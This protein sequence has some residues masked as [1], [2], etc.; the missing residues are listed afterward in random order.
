MKAIHRSVAIPRPV[1]QCVGQAWL[2]SSLA[3]VLALL[4]S[5]TPIQPAAAP[6]PITLRF[7][8]AAGQ[9]SPRIDLY[10][11]EFGT[12][13]HA[14]SQGNITVEPVWDAGADAPDG[15]FE[16]KAIQRVQQGE[17]ELGMAP[18]RAFDI[19]H[20]TSFQPLQAP[21]LIANDA[22]AEA[23]ATSDITTKMLDHLSTADMV[24]L[25]LWPED[26]RH[27]FS[28][29]SGKPLLS[30]QDFAGVN[31]RTPRS[32]LGFQLISALGGTAMYGDG[33]YQG[34]ESGLQQGGTL[35]GKPIATGNVTF[36]PKYEVLFANA[37]AFTRLTDE[38]RMILRQAATA[39]QKKAL[40]N[41]PK[42]VDAA[43]AYCADGG[44][45]V[46]ASDEQVKAFEQAT[47]P[48]FEQ[49]EKDPLN[50]E[51]IAAIRDLKAKVTPAPGAAACGTQA[52][53]QSPA[54]A[55]DSQVWSPGLPPNGTWQVEVTTEDLMR[56][57]ELQSVAVGS[58]GV[59]TWTFQ[60]GKAAGHFQSNQGQS[61]QCTANYA[62]VEDF[63]R[64]TFFDSPDCRSVA[65][66]QWRL[67]ADGLHLH[68]VAIKG[69]PFLE[70]KAYLE[71]KP[72]QQVEAWSPGLPPNGTWQVTL[73]DD[74]FVQMGEL[75][76]VAV[77]SAGVF[78]LTLQDGKSVGHFQS[79]QGQSGQCTATYAV[80]DDF[81]RFTYID[82]PDC[83]G[84]VD[85]MQWRL[86]DDGLHLHLVAIKTAP[87]LENKAY[88]E[89]KPWQKVK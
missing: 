42:E 65:D 81:V 10:V 59:Y 63:V 60:D 35:T 77:E 8:I 76:S 82:S 45:I 17:F 41:R 62:V 49:I 89:A 85:D 46:L 31:V 15:L 14:L 32:D 78:T 23:V 3:L 80:V 84:E 25:T 50:A 74:D 55:V 79:E 64:L 86:D 43:A 51:L 34:A 69:A 54:Q 29:M 83:S 53:Q 4:A 39:T 12:Q 37:A 57:G 87:F 52:A 27:P 26:L 21:F 1:R 9:G 33:D 75:Q 73:T 40:A 19:E 2:L 71:A 47:Q 58:A 70:N 48:V 56:M 36:Y 30:L 24:G 44:T 20:V 38:Q 68:L 13:V 67:D 72:W 22:L 66:I 7:A 18:S 5:C 11:Q 61:G 6:K 88:L 16:A 28:V